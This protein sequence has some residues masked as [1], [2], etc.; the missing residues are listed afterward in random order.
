MNDQPVK[1]L[2]KLDQ[3]CDLLNRWDS[4]V[5]YFAT[6]YNTIIRRSDCESV[7]LSIVE[8]IEACKWAIALTYTSLDMDYEDSLVLFTEL[9]QVQKYSGYSTYQE[10]LA[11][12]HWKNIRL[13]AI[14][15]AGGRCML[16]NS[17]LLPLHV[18]HRTYERLGNE[19]E[20]D[21]I[22]LCAAHHSQFHGKG[23]AE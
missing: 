13:A 12:S 3:L 15:K 6:K 16:C 5:V 7:D 19:S 11:S 9:E 2:S 21:V 20:N 17:D 18:H 14:A 8:A 1:Q 10:Y 22:V 23:G 4:P